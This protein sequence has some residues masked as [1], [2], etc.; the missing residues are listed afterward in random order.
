MP[1]DSTFLKHTQFIIKNYGEGIR[2]QNV[3][4]VAK[5]D[6][7]TPENMQILASINKA[8]SD[9][10]VLGEHEEMID[11]EDICFK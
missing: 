2:M 1:E 11:F 7:L 6:V 8:V 4:I 3:L 9:I 10:K 5:D